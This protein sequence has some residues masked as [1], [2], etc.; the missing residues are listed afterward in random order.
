MKRECLK[1]KKIVI[2]GDERYIRDFL[3]IFDDIVP[4]YCVNDIADDFARDW[5]MLKKEDKKNI[6]VIICKYDELQ[7]IH[8]LKSIGFKR[9][10]NFISAESCF[11]W[12]D[13]PIKEISKSRDV[14]VW[15]TGDD[16]YQFF[17]NYLLRH[18]E[19]HIVAMVDMDP[20]KAKHTFFGK[21][22]YSPQEINRS[23]E[24]FIIIA[25]RKYYTEIRKILENKGMKNREDFIS[26]TGIN[27]YASEMMRRTIFDIPKTSFL[28]EK[29]FKAFEL[30][31]EGRT[32]ICG[33]MHETYDKA[34]PMYYTDFIDIW[35]SNVLKVARLSCVNGTYTFC[36]PVVCCYLRESGSAFVDLNDCKYV[37]EKTESQLQFLKNRKQYPQNTVLNKENYKKRELEYPETVQMGFDE[38]C[39][40]HCPSC[41]KNIYYASPDKIEELRIFKKRIYK[42]IIGN[43]SKIKVAG[44]GEAF[45]STIYKEMLFDQKIANDL[46][47]IGIIS[48]G[49]L[50]TPEV[51]DKLSSLWREINV[52]I[53]MDGA[54][55]KTAEKLRAG[56]RF[57]MW[58][59]NMEYLGEMRQKGKIGK[60]AFN[61]VVQRD[62]YLEMPDYVRMCLKFH[63]DNIKF[64]MLGNWGNWTNEE[65]DELSMID[66]NGE[67]KQELLSVV[68]DEVFK[69]P[70]VF[71]FHWIDW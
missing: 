4:I 51:F 63:A 8:N 41:R 66:E 10:E 13:F 60:F 53:Y 11:S 61:F 69:R 68:K 19:I 43:I 17:Q 71:L 59:Q 23:G 62:N 33:G 21:P 36:D 6:I 58:K 48:N 16:S 32:L 70:E 50:F 55:R 25:T 24:P 27:Q 28:C 65:F 45:A 20:Q 30:K 7:A 44:M 22:I 42:E 47:K 15:G 37:R 38:S 9:E 49:S 56:V 40:F 46:G 5:E 64:S 14:F 31:P 35:N 2:Y 54:S 3:Y 26:Y 57:D 34:E 1:E 12:L 67:M 29:P 52:F 39:N 18:E